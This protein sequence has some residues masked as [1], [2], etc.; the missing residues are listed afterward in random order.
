MALAHQ[1]R[2]LMTMTAQVLISALFI[3][4][5]FF[6]LW[7]FME[8]HVKVPSDYKDM[9]MTLLGVLTA[10]VGIILAFWFQRQREQTPTPPTGG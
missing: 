1:T 5:Y 4:G 3:A 9:F 6:L 2:V 10:G 7:R 8:G